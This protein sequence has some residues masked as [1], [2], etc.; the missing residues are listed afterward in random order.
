MPNLAPAEPLDF[1]L[2]SRLGRI[3]VRWASLEYWISLLLSTL[4]KADHGGMIVVTNSVAV[5]VQSKWIRILLAGHAHEGEQNK[6]VVQLLDRAD[7]L[8]AERNEL[9]HGIWE[10][11][12]EAHTAQVQTAN[13]DRAEIIRTRLVT[14]RDLD[15]LLDEINEWISDYIE[16]GRELGFPRRPGEAQSILAD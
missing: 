2:A 6:R 3:E 8:R 5:S 7:D 12:H 14:I 4:L 11:G 1:E 9:V 10:P 15:E 16:L 13:L